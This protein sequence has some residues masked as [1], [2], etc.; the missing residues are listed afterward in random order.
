MFWAS[1]ALSIHDCMPWNQAKATTVLQN[2]VWDTL[3][4]CRRDPVACLGKQAPTKVNASVALKGRIAKRQLVAFSELS[5][6][7]QAIP[8]FHM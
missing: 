7:S 1:G 4:S 5:Q 8:Q 3:A 2:N 6:L